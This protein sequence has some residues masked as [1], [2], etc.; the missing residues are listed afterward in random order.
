[1][2]FHC[3]APIGLSI[4]GDQLARTSRAIEQLRTNVDALPAFAY[5]KMK[6]GQS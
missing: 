3:H 2:V 1:L 4:E 5:G 6:I